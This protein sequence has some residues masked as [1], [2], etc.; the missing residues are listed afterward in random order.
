MDCS[1]CRGRLKYFL[2][3]LRIASRQLSNVS[4]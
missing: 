1:S 2:F 4:A 3:S